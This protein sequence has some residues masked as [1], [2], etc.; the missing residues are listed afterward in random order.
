MK[1]G[2]LHGG[3]ENFHE[4]GELAF[5]Q[6]Y[7]DGKLD[8]F[9]ESY[10][11][12]GRQTESC[13]WLNGKRHGMLGR[14]SSRNVKTYEA[15]FIL[16]QPD[17]THRTTYENGQTKCELHFKNG[18]RMGTWTR[19]FEGGRLQMVPSFYEDKR[20]GEERSYYE[21]GTLKTLR[22]FRDDK[23]IGLSFLCRENG[24]LINAM[25]YKN[26][27]KDG[28]EYDFDSNM[29]VRN[30]QTWVESVFRTENPFETA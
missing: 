28:V 15:K 21:R 30:E 27:K 20:E 5:W 25:S 17:G 22:R 26:G 1:K 2:I 14:F 9:S 16:G 6:H 12:T 24:T 10:D 4:N 18:K 29:R 13:G 11:K 8:W 19:Y 23:E 7:L 3:W